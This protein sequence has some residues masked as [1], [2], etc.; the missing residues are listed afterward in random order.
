M[1][2]DKSKKIIEKILKSNQKTP[3]RANLA[4]CWMEEINGRR[5]QIATN[6]YYVI[7]LYEEYQVDVP[8]ETE[9][10]I[11]NTKL[12][13][14]KRNTESVHKTDFNLVEIKKKLSEYKK[15][16]KE[17]PA[18]ALEDLGMIEMGNCLFNMEYF[19]NCV[20]ALGEDTILYLNEVNTHQSYFESSKGLAMLFPIKK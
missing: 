10:I 1:K 7:A 14:D 16:K 19:I 8:T 13:F 5:M 20:E 15:R 17:L 4:T 18:S 12:V 3:Q 2:A 11:I 9:R 6:L